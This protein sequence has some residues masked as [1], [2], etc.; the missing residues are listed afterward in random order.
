MT[1]ADFVIVASG[2]G[3]SGPIHII[4]KSTHAP[5]TAFADSNSEQNFGPV[6]NDQFAFEYRPDFSPPH[7]FDGSLGAPASDWLV[8]A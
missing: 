8:A 4:Q 1:H 3:K 2:K 6:H 7:L 5:E